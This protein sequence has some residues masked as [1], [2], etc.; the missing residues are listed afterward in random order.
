MR[1]RRKRKLIIDERMSISAEEMKSQL[2]DTSDIIAIFDSAP[3]TKKLMK[4][5]ET[6]GVEKLFGIPGHQ[7][8]SKALSEGFLKHLTTRVLENEELS[9]EEIEKTK[10]GPSAKQKSKSKKGLSM[11]QL[12][13]FCAP[14]NVSNYLK[15][16]S[17]ISN[18][19]LITRGLSTDSSH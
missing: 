7:I 9:E 17:S 8:P 4:W 6:A 2:S 11:D 13:H 5:K 1:T 15:S 10:L 19:V 18:V 14:T 16:S 12:I 3:P